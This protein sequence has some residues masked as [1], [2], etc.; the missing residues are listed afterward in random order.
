MEF[1][2]PN[3]KEFYNQESSV[4]GKVVVREMLRYWRLKAVYAQDNLKRCS[5]AKRNIE[6]YT[7]MLQ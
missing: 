5:Y 1:S 4:D 3:K 6:N 2:I 7:K